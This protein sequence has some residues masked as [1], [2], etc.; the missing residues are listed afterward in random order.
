MKKFTK[1]VL[2]IAAVFVVT[3][4]GFVIAGSVTAGGMGALR[5]QLR[6]GELNFDNWHFE[7]GIYYHK[8]GSNH[9]GDVRIDMSDIVQEGMN[10][11]PVGT[12]QAEDEFSKTVKR[13]ELDTDLASITV[14]QTNDDKLKVSLRE[15]YTKYYNAKENGDTLSISYDV[16]GHTFKQGPKIIVELPEHMELKELYIDNDLG[17]VVLQDLEESLRMI[18]VYADLGN[19]RIEECKAYKEGTLVVEAALGNIEV[20]DSKFGKV[21][22]N[23]NMGNVDFNGK[24]TGD[25]TVQADMGNVE[26]ELDGKE[27]DY[28]IRMKANMGDVIYNSEKQN[29]DFNLQQEDAIGEIVLTCA[30][31]NVEL[32]FD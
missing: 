15:G 12:E 28:N 16:S 13:I 31:G 26:V 21:D 6:S 19:V 25:I 7:D 24:V 3:G 9:H 1:I 32:E 30:M 23:A 29:G 11:L 22:L 5:E 4:V 17:E 18:E 27:K 14:K 8:D 10:L 20:E 2:I